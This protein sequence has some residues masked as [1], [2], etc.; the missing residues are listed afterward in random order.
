M[1]A[2]NTTVTQQCFDYW[3][4]VTLPGGSTFPTTG[5]LLGPVHVCLNAGAS[6][7]AHLTHGV[8]ISAPVGAYVFN[9]FVG[10]FP[11]PVRVVIDSAHFN[12]DV[13]AFGPLTNHPAIS[14]SLIENGFRK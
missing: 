7:T 5:A 3:E 9:S 2:I 12:F 6:R 1:T 13:T 8:P 4:D 10:T 14:W 11:V